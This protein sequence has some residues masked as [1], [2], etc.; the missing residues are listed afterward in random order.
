MIVLVVIA[1]ASVIC[2][3]AVLLLARR[4]RAERDVLHHVASEV[5]S[6]LIAEIDRRSQAARRVATCAREIRAECGALRAE[7]RASY[8]RLADQHVES[9]ATIAELSAELDQAHRAGAVVLADRAALAR[10]CVELARQVTAVERERD[11]R[12][13]AIEALT[14]RIAEVAAARDT[15]LGLVA[16]DA[17]PSP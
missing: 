2:A 16:V 4:I 6:R 5:T 10:R 17:E 12:D 9:T 8:Q 15:A 14:A 1:V 7:V 13:R 11:A 3:A